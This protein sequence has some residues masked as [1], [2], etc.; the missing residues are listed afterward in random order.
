MFRI[1]E[2]KHAIKDAKYIDSDIFPLKSTPFPEDSGYVKKFYKEK[3]KKT[4][5]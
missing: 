1:D 2:G 3:N 4:N 5:K